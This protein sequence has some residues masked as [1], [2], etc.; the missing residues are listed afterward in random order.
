MSPTRGEWPN[1]DLVLIKDRPNPGAGTPQCFFR[2]HM[3]IPF[4]ENKWKPL[5]ELLNKH[6]SAGVYQELTKNIPGSTQGGLA[7]KALK[8][9]LGL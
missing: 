1:M 9:A 8:A 6:D 4:P 2:L 7:D 3:D 5:D